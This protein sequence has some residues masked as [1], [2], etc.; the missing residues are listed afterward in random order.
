MV[1]SYSSHEDVANDEDDHGS[2]RGRLLS[3]RVVVRLSRAT[4]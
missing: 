4:G 1:R 2:L 3:G